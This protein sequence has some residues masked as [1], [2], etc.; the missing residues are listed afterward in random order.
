LSF[1]WHVSCFPIH[2]QPGR[3]NTY[4]PYLDFEQT[5]I[6]RG[7]NVLQ[8][9]FIDHF[10][11][12]KE[13]YN[14][15]YATTYGNYR[16]ERIIEV[17]EEFIK[18]GDYKEGLARV[19]CQN[20][21]CG[22]DFFVPLSCLSFYLCPSCH[23]KRMLLFGEQIAQEVLLK[24][25][26]RQFVFTLPKCLRIYFKH[27]RLLYS[28][29]SQLIFN[30][31]QSYYNE[32]S[33]RQIET[34]LVLSYQTSGDFARWHPHWHGLLLEGGFDD[35]GNFVYLPVSNTKGMTELFRRT[36]IK[37]FEDNKLINKD[38][39][40]N[41]LSWKNSG[42]SI[43]NSVRLFSSDDNAKEALAQYIARCPIALDK[44]KYEPLHGN[45]LFKTPKYNDYFKENFKTFNALDTPL[46]F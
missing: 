6:P 18:C 28:D 25:P 29:I 9:I 16:I 33:G 17:V 2:V 12:F 36:C 34:G 37:H 1:L 38:F 7:T 19:K 43:D 14:D 22:H 15:K 40:R 26:H 11:K 35:D 46:L 30:L 44:I 27:N 5:Y 24:L 23:Q 13:Q 20:P 45:V 39:A 3:Q 4:Q 8:C 21:D 31:I 42:F 32:A 41:L 10:A